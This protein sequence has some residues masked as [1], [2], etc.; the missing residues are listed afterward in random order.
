[1][2]EIWGFKDDLPVF[3]QNDTVDA[4][5]P[6]VNPNIIVHVY[7]PLIIQLFFVQ[8]LSVALKYRLI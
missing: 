6:D 3:I 5:R 8:N 4:N 1:M 7:N 2:T